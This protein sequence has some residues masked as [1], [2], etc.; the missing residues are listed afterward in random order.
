[1]RNIDS[2][3]SRT[4]KLIKP[5][6][7]VL[8]AAL[9]LVLAIRLRVPPVIDEVSTI[10][11]PALMLGYNWEEALFAM[12]GCYFKYGPSL[13]YYPLMRIFEDP[14]VFYKSMLVLNVLIYAFIPVI[15][16]DILK[17]HL[18]LGYVTSAA[19]AHTTGILP[20]TLLYTL[21]AR[22]DA[23]L[24]FLPWPMLLVI[25]ELVALEPGAKGSSIARKTLARRVVLSVIL[26]AMTAYAYMAHT[27]GIVLILAVTLSV[28]LIRLIAGRRTVEWISYIV[29]LGGICLA[30]KKISAYF[31][32]ALYGKYGASFSSVES[33]DF[34]SLKQI[35]TRSGF[36]SFMKIAAGTAFNVMTTSYGL[37]G[38]AVI[39]SIVILIVY[40]KRRSAATQA[41]I[42]VMIFTVLSFLGT[43]AM[44]CIYFF[45]YA[46]PI[47]SGGEIRRVDWLV[48]GRY[49]AC[50]LG[51]ATLLGLYFL[52]HR[53][54][55]DR[56][57]T[58]AKLITV[59]T[60]VIGWTGVFVIFMKKV[61]P[62]MQGASSVSRNYIQLCTFLKLKSYGGT[63]AVFENLSDAMLYAG[64]LGAIV[65]AAVLLGSLRPLS[66]RAR[67]IIIGIVF[68]AVSGTVSI[69]NYNKIRYSR[70][71]VLYTCTV[72]PVTVLRDLKEL[73]D[74]YHI[75]VDSSA[76]DI[77]HYQFQLRDFVCGNS[78][79][80][81]I[82]A[83]NYFVVAKKGYFRKVYGK[84]DLYFFAD[85]DYENATKDIVYVKG[86]KLADELN[87]MGYSVLKY[88]GKYKK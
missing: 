15:A 85:F 59:I 62:V 24:I 75:I 67:V 13:L 83:D 9:G 37:A 25:L 43:F 11:S 79:T 4:D 31:H 70:D 54:F 82:N 47:Y 55:K 80:D 30:D 49:A 21:Y 8:T 88:D 23:M 74:S 64:I 34:E 69:V 14:Y 44:S 39:G 46:H 7:Y 40:I 26:A 5:A 57:E 86:A 77:K 66:E 63:T 41:E 81:S 18:G 51:P 29:T 17:K 27:R 20:S 3:Y 52:V 28:L 53:N 36:A 50:S 42:A 76:K 45:P 78:E 65:G 58:A 72:E 61:A 35:F 87:K 73:A 33:Y 71:E 19:L 2:S 56:K 16:Y 60:T 38:I 32:D 10:A 12:G 1:M 22:A 68:I 6:L 84:G 48:Y